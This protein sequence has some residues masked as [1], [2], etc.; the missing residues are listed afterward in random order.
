MTPRLPHAGDLTCAL[1]RSWTGTSATGK[2]DH[3]ELVELSLFPL[4][5]VLFLYALQIF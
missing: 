5:L 4:P 1:E 2:V 3:D